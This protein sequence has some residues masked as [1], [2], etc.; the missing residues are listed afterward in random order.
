MAGFLSADEC[1]AIRRA[2]D[3]GTTEDAEVLIAG[4]ERRADIRRAALVEPDPAVLA[5]V[6]ARLEGCRARV[7]RALA[8]SLGGR[9]GTSF[10]R[11]PDGGF[12]RPHI[13]RADDPAWPA[14]GRRAVA[15][16][17]F[18]NSSGHPASGGGFDGGILRLH[19]PAGPIDVV[20]AAGLL[21]AF[22]ADLLH[23]V[24]AVRGGGRDTLVDWF[25]EP[26]WTGRAP[27]G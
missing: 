2:M 13:D 14:A 23:E 4:T 26:P 10:L 9:E 1:L 18:L 19:A 8:M 21:V 24:T 6:E 15:L 22:R 12:Y 5:D 25:Y 3:R 7:E 20:P 17:V 11:Y 16:V 27:S